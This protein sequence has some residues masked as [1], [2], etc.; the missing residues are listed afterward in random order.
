MGWD[1]FVFEGVDV[2]L[3][4]T[5]ETQYIPSIVTESR[6]GTKYTAFANIQHPPGIVSILINIQP[7]GSIQL[8]RSTTFNIPKPP[9]LTA[10]LLHSITP[11]Q[12]A[13]PKSNFESQTHSP[14]PSSPPSPPKL[15]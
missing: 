11:H 15:Q 3:D 9:S 12:Q 2:L 4:S 10:F 6:C 5:L 7:Y 14:L 8:H 13:S 1:V